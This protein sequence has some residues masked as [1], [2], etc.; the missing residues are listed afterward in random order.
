MFAG[1]Q[2]LE[3]IQPLDLAARLQNDTD[4]TVVVD[5]R[6]DD[7]EG[8]HI[9]GCTHASSESLEDDAVLC[10]LVKII[11]GHARVVVHCMKSQQ[12]GPMVAFR[13]IN[14]LA[15]ILEEE[16]EQRTTSTN[17][18]SIL[19]LRGGYEGFVKECGDLYPDLYE[20]G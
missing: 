19:V 10:N 12:R 16:Q 7:F 9:K 20:G 5:C 14:R 8:G 17:K 4:D 13:L 2:D 3:Y 15:I 1:L 18:P 6:D 11:R